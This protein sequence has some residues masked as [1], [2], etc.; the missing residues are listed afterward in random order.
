MCKCSPLHQSS[1]GINTDQNRNFLFTKLQSRSVTSPISL[2]ISPQITSVTYTAEKDVTSTTTTSQTV[3]PG[4]RLPTP[5]TTPIPLP[6]PP[7]TP[8]VNSPPTSSAPSL[9]KTPSAASLA[10]S[11]SV[12][13]AR[14]LSPPLSG[15]MHP[16]P[17]VSSP[18]PPSAYSLPVRSMVSGDITPP[19]SPVVVSPPIPLSIEITQTS[20]FPPTSP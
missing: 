20:Y 13:S 14:R 15:P 17:I 10:S 16:A 19:V 2:P 8:P 1:L 7:V 11:T 9:P 5:P 6:T 4:S 18:P 3:L 12:P